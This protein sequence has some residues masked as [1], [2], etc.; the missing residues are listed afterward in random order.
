M[1][2]IYFF[3]YLMYHEQAHITAM[4]VFILLFI[5]FGDFPIE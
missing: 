5:L 4:N 3:F 2:F 1:F